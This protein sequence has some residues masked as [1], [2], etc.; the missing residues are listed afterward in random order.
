ME[1]QACLEHVKKEE[2]RVKKIYVLVLLL[3]VLCFINPAYLFAEETKEAKQDT[4]IKIQKELMQELNKNEQGNLTFRAKKSALWFIKP[5]ADDKE[6]QDA[7][8]EVTLPG[9]IYETPKQVIEVSMRKVDRST[10]E[11]EAASVFSA[12]RAGNIKWIVENFV[13]E[14]QDRVTMTFK[15]KKLLKDS[16]MDAKSVQA[17]YITG[18]A[19]YKDYTILFIEQEYGKNGKN[20]KVTEAIACKQTPEGWKL[21]NAIASDETFDI[22]FAAVS[23]GEV[24]DGN[25]NKGRSN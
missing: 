24:L 14:D 10:I 25:K 11:G 12:G 7:T 9:E 17:E 20:K 22:V 4:K 16:K 8:V 18:K 13:K 21:T 6:S 2:K 3:L 15:D 23:N 1:T 5:N 19:R